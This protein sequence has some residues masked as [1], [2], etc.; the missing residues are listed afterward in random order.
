MVDKHDFWTSMAVAAASLAAMLPAILAPWQGL[1]DTYKVLLVAGPVAMATCA[2]IGLLKDR[3]SEEQRVRAAVEQQLSQLR[4][5]LRAEPALEAG[6]AMDLLPPV[7]AATAPLG[8]AVEALAG[9]SLAPQAPATERDDTGDE[10]PQ[11][12]QDP[13][14]LPAQ[15]AAGS[16][17]DPGLARPVVA[18]F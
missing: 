14:P 2:Y 6:N 8:N 5:A 7:A 4:L 3:L 9:A 18:P 16:D 17:H 11:V 1:K 13:L 12:A 15:G 10:P